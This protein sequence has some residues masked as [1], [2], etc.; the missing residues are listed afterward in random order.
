MNTLSNIIIFSLNELRC[1]VSLDAVERVVRMVEITP[2][3][4]AMPPL[5]GII[6]VQGHVVPVVDL[7]DRFGFAPQ[8]VKPADQLMI[9]RWKERA[10]ALRVD[11][12][13]EVSSFDNASQTTSDDIL[14]H[15]PFLAGVVKTADGLILIHDLDQLLSEQDYR[16][17]QHQLE[18][19]ER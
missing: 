13:C 10:L 14:P 9:V 2:L 3:P 5:E 4:G 7:R 11:T 19:Q 17:V 12:V 16:S 1:A 8:P 15:L 18:E 6:N